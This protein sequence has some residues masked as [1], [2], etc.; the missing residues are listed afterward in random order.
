[1]NEINEALLE[2]IEELKDIVW[3]VNCRLKSVRQAVQLERG[4]SEIG[5]A[6]EKIAQSTEPAPGR[7]L[8]PQP[9][10]HAERR[11]SPP[12]R[13]EL[14]PRE[15]SSMKLKQRFDFQFKSLIRIID[16]QAEMDSA[17]TDQAESMYKTLENMR[18]G[19]DK[20][21]DIDKENIVVEGKTYNINETIEAWIIMIYIY[22]DKNKKTEKKEE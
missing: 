17:T 12:R 6:I 3:R 7:P 14:A 2:I 19:L 8:A 9:P 10:I 11:R 21:D 22:E 15:N 13:T 1:M 16:C 4:Y 5:G 18:Q 20:Y